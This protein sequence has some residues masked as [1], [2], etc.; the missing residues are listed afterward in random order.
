MVDE[1]PLSSIDFIADIQ[2][3]DGS[4]PDVFV[5]PAVS[6]NLPVNKRLE[7]PAG[8]DDDPSAVRVFEP[9]IERFELI[10]LSE[11][12]SLVTGEFQ[13]NETNTIASLALEGVEVLKG[14]SRYKVAI[15]VK[16][17]EIF[18]D[19]SSHIIRD[20][21][22]EWEDKKEL[23][24]VTGPRPTNIPESNVLF[25][26]PIKNQ[27]YFL[28]NEVDGSSGIRWTRPQTD[29]FARTIEDVE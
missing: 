1:N 5:I 11:G 27:A 17:I 24:F 28:Q 13:F 16:A 3:G 15:I 29:L 25:S 14:E 26:Y 22:R 2:P 23:T 9:Y 20:E 8:L 7:L 18:P 21:G 10:D 4:N 12:N 19:G 6:F